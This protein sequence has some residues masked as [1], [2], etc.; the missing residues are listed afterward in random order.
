MEAMLKRKYTILIVL[1][2]VTRLYCSKM[3]ICDLLSSNPSLIKE[4][5][6]ALGTPSLKA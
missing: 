5:L 4:V 3:E 6:S 1:V 2:E